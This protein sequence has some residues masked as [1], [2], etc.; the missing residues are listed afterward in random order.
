[1]LCVCVS[2]R[3]FCYSIIVAF[4]TISFPFGYVFHFCIAGGVL[5]SS[6]PN[7]TM[8]LNYKIG[9]KNRIACIHTLYVCV[10]VCLIH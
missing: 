4:S 3:F 7:Q 6:M 1:M 9:T 10:C 5:F 8:L 2:I